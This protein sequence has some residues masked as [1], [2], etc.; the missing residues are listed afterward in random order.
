VKQ[1][2]AL[3]LDNLTTPV[4]TVSVNLSAALNLDAAKAWL[5]FT[6]A[7]GGGWQSH[8]ILSWSFQ[9][10]D[11][12]LLASN[13]SVVEGAA[14]TT[15]P[16]NFTIS[17]IGSTAGSATVNWT[18]ADGTAKAGTD[19]V[20]ASGT[21]TFAAGDA[22]PKT[23]TV[24]A[25][26]NN[27]PGPD[28][29]FKLNLSTT[30]SSTPV[31]GQ[32]TIRNDDTAVSI[33]HDSI[34]EGNPMNR[35]FGAFI[36]GVPSGLYTPY[37]MVVGLDGNLYVSAHN[38]GGVYRY[39]AT[40]GQPLPALGK[41][42]AEFV[43]PGDGGSSLA[44]DLAFG[45]DGYLYV[46]SESANAVIRYDPTTGAFAGTLIASGSGGLYAPRGLAF[47]N[48]YVYVTSVGPD[49]TPA[50]GTDSVLRYNFTDGSPAGVSGQPGDAVFIPTASG[51]LDNP[52]RIVFGPDGKAY[53]SSTA[54]TSVRATSNSVL[55]YDPDTGAP[56]GV[57]GQ[58]GDAV[59]VGPS[60]GGL[61]GPIAMVFRADGYLYVTGWRSNAVFRYDGTT[62]APAGQM[63]PTA[64]GGLN[65]AIDL[66]FDPAGNL[67]V[68]SQ[69]T[70]QILRFG[71]AT[72]LVFTVSLS[73]PSAVPTTVNYATAE[74]TAKAGTDYVAT[75]GSVTF[76]PGETTKTIMVPSI[77]DATVKGT[78][79]FTVNLSLPAAGVNTGTVTIA[80]GTGTGTVIDSTKFGTGIDGLHYGSNFIGA[81][82]PDTIAA[83]GAVNVV[84]M[85]N[86]GIAIYTKSGIQ[87]S[88]QSFATFFSSI[89]SDP[90]GDLFDPV[91]FY[92]DV[93]GRFVVAAADVDFGNRTSNLLVAVSNDSD[94][95]HGFTEMHKINTL[96]GS[97]GAAAWS[98][99]PRAGYSA[100]AYVFD[101]NMFGFNTGRYKNVQSIRIAKASVLDANNSTFTS[102]KS[103]FSSSYDFTLTPARQ[104]G[105]AAG[106]PVW[107]VEEKGRGNGK[108]IRLVKMTNP[109]SNSPTL[110]TYDVNVPTYGVPPAA[111]SPGG[112]LM[113]TNDN[114]ILDVTL[115]GGRLVV[116]QE[117]GLNGLATARMYEFT[118]SGTPTLKQTVNIAPGT[119]IH[120]YFPAVD[121]NAAGTIGMTYVESSA[122]EF[123]STYVTAQLAGG[124]MQP[125]VVAQAGQ[126]TYTAFDGSPHRA[127]DYGGISVDPVDGSFWAANEYATGATSNNWGTHVRN[128]SLASIGSL[129]APPGPGSGISWPPDELLPTEGPF[130]AAVSG[131]TSLTERDAVFTL[132]VRELLSRLGESVYRDT[133]LPV[134][135]R[136]ENPA[137]DSSTQKLLVPLTPLTSGNNHSIPSSRSA[138]GL[139]DD[140]LASG[141]ATDFFAKLTDGWSTKV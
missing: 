87:V 120:T 83:A 76:G 127:G 94:A 26:G 51:G 62:G 37:A 88:S 64:N 50:A 138:A 40:T 30:A 21:V 65:T 115:R 29:T 104:H 45:P 46:V 38:G 67:L 20:A 75:S 124:T 114:R 47:R 13:P 116:A 42:A 141:V 135:E 54:D 110:T 66:L 5:G 52:S 84:E 77:S 6:G 48:G 12:L 36:S 15:T 112:V 89:T 60:S 133:H 113:D 117:V 63:M 97:G 33:G 34:V 61:D 69:N 107:L 25:I 57:S 130:P 103:D 111:T 108:T 91:V 86:S 27:T 9:G 119:G 98:D 11:N 118:V 99:F 90:V 44:R 49:N 131:G 8:D 71:A 7:T 101:F 122:T 134:T 23:V 58:P 121:V 100:D 128:F 95:T 35:S 72:Q 140:N 139:W 106:D 1:Q 105:A 93:A 92:D 53:V 22:A 102:Y 31:W 59:F 14:T 132:A 41:V 39:D 129:Q 43:T 80:G 68:T 70:N 24:T 74:G 126:A 81:V 78:A 109:L 96:E 73:Y 4:L 19:Y 32:A 16:V 85:V 55:R 82:P 2:T 79:A 136:V 56:A 28:K 137:G 123:V 3:Y 18:T 10:D 125:G 17:R